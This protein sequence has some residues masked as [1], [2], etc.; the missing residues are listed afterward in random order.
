MSLEGK[1]KY[2]RILRSNS[3]LSSVSLIRRFPIT[4][5]LLGLARGVTS[6]VAVVAN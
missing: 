6:V 3:D 5:I 4:L 2:L 1:V